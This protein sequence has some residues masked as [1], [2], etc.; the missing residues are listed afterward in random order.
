MEDLGFM[1]KIKYD[2]EATNNRYYLPHH[3]IIQTVNRTKFRVVFNASAKTSNG[4]SINDELLAG[5][6]LQNDLFSII[7]RFRTFPYV[8]TTDIEKM[9]LQ[10]RVSRSL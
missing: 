8:I 6:N 2:K 1:V 4:R 9:F 10:I 3:G 7:A 5:P